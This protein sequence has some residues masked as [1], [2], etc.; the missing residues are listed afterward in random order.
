MLLMAVK[1]RDDGDDGY[2]ELL[3]LMRMRM[4]MMMVDDEGEEVAPE[5][6]PW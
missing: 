4:K 6:A 5:D 2:C 3:L 1:R